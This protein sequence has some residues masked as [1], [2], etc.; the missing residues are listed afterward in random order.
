MAEGKEQKERAIVADHF[1][2]KAWKTDQAV[3]LVSHKT[4]RNFNPV[5]A[6]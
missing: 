6:G 5:A 3:K 1:G 4:A 2:A